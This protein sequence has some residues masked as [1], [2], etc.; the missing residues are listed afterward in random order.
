MMDVRNN[1]SSQIQLSPGISIR[2]KDKNADGHPAPY[3]E[4]N[5]NIIE[6]E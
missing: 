2:S 3:L 5:F 6:N 4:G 1:I